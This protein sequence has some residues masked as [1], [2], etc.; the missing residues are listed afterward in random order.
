[1]N[2]GAIVPLLYMA[3]LEKGMACEYPM[4]QFKTGYKSDTGKDIYIKARPGTKELALD[5]LRK[6]VE[7]KDSF[8]HWRN[9]HAF[10]FDP[11][12]IP[13]GKCQ[14]CLMSYAGELTTRM[15]LEKAYWKNAYFITLTYYEPY[16]PIDKETGQAIILKEELQAF[17]KRFYYHLPG[18][19]IS[20]GEYGS[21]NSRPHY[22]LIYLSNDELPLKQFAIN[23]FTSPVI[24]KTWPYGLHEVSIADTGCIAYV[25]GYV[26]KKAK[27]LAENDDHKPFRLL[28]RGLGFGYLEEHDVLK[29]RFV[30]GDFG[31][32]CKRRKVPGAFIRKLESKGIDCSEFKDWNKVNG[33]RFQDILQFEYDTVDVDEL[34]GMRRQRLNERFK[35][36]RKEKF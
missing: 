2:S 10:L 20:C 30:Y 8:I 22:H 7:I 27:Q 32:N 5:G 36:Q 12:P 16:L 19:Y 23:K 26:L 11:V 6:K 25:A 17:L 9:G 24:N 1:M 29:D 34:G 33:E 3:P 35:K 13:C 4:V 31:E 18:V 28:S 21:K 15:V 14:A